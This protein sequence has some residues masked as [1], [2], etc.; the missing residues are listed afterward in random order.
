L[1][2]SL[3]QHDSMIKAPI[4]SCRGKQRVPMKK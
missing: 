1:E 2:T 3:T 4:G